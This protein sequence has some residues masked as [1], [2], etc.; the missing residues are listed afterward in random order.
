MKNT[1]PYPAI[2][3]FP[4]LNGLRFLAAALVVI[5]HIHNNMGISDL[6]QLPSFPGLFK[7]L[8][9]VAFFFVLSGFLITW[10]LLR[11]QDRTGTIVIKKFYLRRVFRIWPLYFIVIA[12]GC[13]FYW[14]L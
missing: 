8:Y 11:E 9:A 3:W 14:R 13:L 4:G 6:P 2:S 5:M 7:G 1:H 10:L 12:I